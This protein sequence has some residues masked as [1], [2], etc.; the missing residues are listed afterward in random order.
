MRPAARRAR[1]ILGATC[2]VDAM[3]TLQIAVQIARRR[4]ADLHGLL[5]TDEAILAAASGPRARAVA[6]FGGQ[7]APISPARM[8]DAFR[9]DAR[10]FETALLRAAQ[11]ASLHA[12]FRQAQ[13]RLATALDDAAGAGDLLVYGFAR[14]ERGADCVVL[15][16]DGTAPDADLTELAA[17]LASHPDRPL[18]ALC[19]PGAEAALRA[20]LDVHAAPGA[21]AP[22]VVPVADPSA[23]L[24]Q[25]ERRRPAAVIAAA[26]RDAL[27]PVGRLLDAAR[28]PVIFAA[29]PSARLPAP[30]PE[31][32]WP[33]DP[34]DRAGG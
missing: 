8:L 2:S 5:V 20:A 7:I 32:P 14:P 34:T 27:P 12:A 18:V 10:R 22:V 13:G 17:Q 31:Q 21:Q 23:L 3:G 29:D 11:A 30:S 16:C 24:D 9:A 1:V 25:L 33:P 28:C 26:P 15:L 6:F 19:P 4:G